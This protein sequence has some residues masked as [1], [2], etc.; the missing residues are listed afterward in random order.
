ME[1]IREEARPD[2]ML[3]GPKS[4]REANKERADVIDRLGASC[5][6]RNG[7]KD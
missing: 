5:L 3:K 7:D 2:A 6:H 1:I 4:L